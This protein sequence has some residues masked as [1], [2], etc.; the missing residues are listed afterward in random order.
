MVRTPGLQGRGAG[1]VL[2]TWEPALHCLGREERMVLVLKITE[3][4]SV[5]MRD[6]EVHRSGVGRA[7]AQFWGVRGRVQWVRVVERPTAFYA[8]Q[9]MS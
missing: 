3:N 1:A 8:A 5:R 6:A 4:W 7:V 9:V 2:C